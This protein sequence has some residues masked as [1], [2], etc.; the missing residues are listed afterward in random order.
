M[1][2]ELFVEL[3]FII[4]L[5]LVTSIAANILKQ[6]L[7]IAYILTGILITSFFVDFVTFSEITLIFSKIGI[8]F[9]LFMVGL[10]LNPKVIK[11]IGVVATVTGLG[12]IIFTS[13]I[14]FLISFYLGFSVIESL[15]ISVALTFSSTIIIMKLL[16]DKDDLDT[17]YG[18]ISIGFLIVQDLVAIFLLMF[19]PLA[20]NNLEFHIIALSIIKGILLIFFIW[21]LSIQILP[22]ITKQIAKNQELLF[23]FSVG[24]CFLIASLFFYF[25]FSIEIG[26]LLAGIGLS[27]SQYRLEI[28]Y[29]VKPLR[30]FFIIIFFIILGSQMHISS[31]SSI[32]LPAIV[33]S[34]FILIGNPLIV[35]I[36]MGLLGYTK[37]N[38]F[39]AGLTV[40]QISEFSLILIALGVNMNHISPQIL[41]LVTLVGLITITASTYMIIYSEKIYPIIS[42]HL[43]I[44][45]KKNILKDD[46][47]I[48]RDYE[49]VLFGYNRIGYNILKS[50]DRLKIK[51]IV[52]DFDPEVI[53]DLSK[54]GKR[55]I[56]G[57][58]DDAELF[59]DLNLSNIKMVI[60]TI[61]KIETNSLIIKEVKRKNPNSIVMVTSHVIEDSLK[62]YNTGADYV[63]MPHFLGGEYVS[64]M[65][66]K[67]RINRKDYSKESK[68]QISGLKE[69][70]KEGHRHP[71]IEK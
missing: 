43:E 66:E 45:E 31:V 65:I 60:S 1:V 3:T 26:A 27:M 8:A 20:S 30:D 7:M 68:D 61:P 10:N 24:W 42:R 50:L 62:L 9:L 15:Y 14:G 18:K 56:Y 13:L 12:Q 22:R 67:N 11:E 38:G 16:S 2:Q 5:A 63:I 29:K 6:P 57:D 69:R 70:I 54:N 44:F 39:L 48:K 17:L 28:A 40:A 58:A 19:I 4:L 37:R 64:K 59:N 52:I 35:M 25:G 46:P 23:L 49:A 33:L 36:L 21:L 47:K 51:Y 41:S 55:C 32:V 53:V 71:R 34:L